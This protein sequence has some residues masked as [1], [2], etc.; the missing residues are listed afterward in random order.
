MSHSL[1]LPRGGA[2][3]YRVALW[4]PELISHVFAV[5]TPYWPPSD[6]FE[7]LDQTV[8]RRYSSFKYQQHFSSGEIEEAIQSRN[9]IG[10]FLNGAYG[11]RGP[12]R[13]VG[14]RMDDR[15]YLEHLAKLRPTSLLTEKVCRSLQ[16]GL[17][18]VVGTV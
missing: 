11:G 18:N 13:E 7:T 2:I 8:K 17:P 15:V 12:N 9:E 1:N 6:R 3:V 10:H 14:M 5:C 4:C 16:F